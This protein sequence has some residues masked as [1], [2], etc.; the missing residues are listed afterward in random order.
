MVVQRVLPPVPDHVLGDVDHDEVAR[1][2][3][4]DRAHVREHRP[5]DLP[6]RRVQDPQGHRDVH[7]LPLLAQDVDVLVG[8]D[9]E[10]AVVLH[11][12][13]VFGERCIREWLSENNTCPKCRAVLFEADEDDWEL[14]Q[15]SDFDSDYDMDAEME[16]ED[17][18]DDEDE[19]EEPPLTPTQFAELCAEEDYEVAV[20]S[21]LLDTNARLSRFRHDFCWVREMDVEETGGQRDE[22]ELM[23][24]YLDGTAFPDFDPEILPMALANDFADGTLSVDF[25]PEI[26]PM[27]AID[28]L[29]R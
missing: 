29:A 21:G 8:A 14:D 15:E 17:E 9:D 20:S 16:D 19:N 1:A 5:G 25:D 28:S 2:V 24:V 10:R 3:P 26:M 18:D 4:S 7:G 27:R 22:A 13:H 11:D 23:E 12:R 6:E